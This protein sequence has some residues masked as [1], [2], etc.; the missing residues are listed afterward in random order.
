MEIWWA[1][2]LYQWA[3]RSKAT[4]L[5]EARLKTAL[6]RCDQILQAGDTTSEEKAVRLFIRG[7][8]YRQLG[9][10][11]KAS[12]DFSA[13]IDIPDISD[14]QKAA[15]LL[16]RG[17]THDQRGNR[18]QAIT[19]YTSVIQMPGAPPRLRAESLVARGVIKGQE[20]QLDAAIDDYTAVV[21]MASCSR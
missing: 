8:V 10:T 4:S 11:E 19:D 6:N 9:E 7:T 14:E 17:W 5:A 16:S 1:T 15:C 12:A 20:P 18:E 3:L 2:L 13:G 21:E